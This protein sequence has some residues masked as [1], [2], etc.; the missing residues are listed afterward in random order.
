MSNTA[1]TIELDSTSF[2]DAIR[3]AVSLGGDADT[4]AA[5]DLVDSRQTGG[6]CFRGFV[7][8]QSSCA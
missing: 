5:K 3:N 2:E 7:H 1:H 8:L 4:Q 6:W